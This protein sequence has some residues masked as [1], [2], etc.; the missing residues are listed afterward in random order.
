MLDFADGIE[1]YCNNSAARV[2]KLLPTVLA[3]AF[4]GELVPTEAELARRGGR[5]YESASGLLERVRKERAEHDGRAPS[6]LDKQLAKLA[7]ATV[8]DM[9]RR[10]PA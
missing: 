1:G 3:K 5:N 2:E 7:P 6:W 8:T 10:R 9:F 4:R